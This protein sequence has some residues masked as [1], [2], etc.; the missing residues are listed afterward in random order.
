M[1]NLNEDLSSWAIVRANEFK[2]VYRSRSLLKNSL[3]FRCGRHSKL[4]N[5]TKNC[6]LS[7]RSYLYFNQYNQ[8]H[9]TRGKMKDFFMF[10]RK[11][12]RQ[13]NLIDKLSRFLDS[14]PRL[15]HN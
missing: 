15:A 10:T 13:T 8:S 1:P 14:R 11:T 6:N 5:F 2:H 12:G 4:K 3:I 7:E 9:V